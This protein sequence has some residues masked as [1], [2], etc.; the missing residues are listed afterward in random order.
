[1]DARTGMPRWEQPISRAFHRPFVGAPAPR[2]LGVTDHGTVFLYDYVIDPTVRN[3]SP[4]GNMCVLAFSGR[5]G[6]PLGFYPIRDGFRKDRENYDDIVRVFALHGQP[7]QMAD[8]DA[9]FAGF[10]AEWLG[11]PPP[12]Q[13]A[14]TEIYTSPRGGWN[15]NL[16]TKNTGVFG[17]PFARAG[18][19]PPLIGGEEVTATGSADLFFRWNPGRYAQHLRLIHP[20]PEHWEPNFVPETQFARYPVAQCPG[21]VLLGSDYANGFVA[22]LSPDAPDNRYLRW[23]R[24]W[25]FSL[26][27]PAVYGDEILLGAGLGDATRAIVSL[28]AGS[29]V[30]RWT[31]APEGL[32]PD[33]LRGDM[34]SVTWNID[35]YV[36]GTSLDVPRSTPSGGTGAS[37][38]GPGPALPGRSRPSPPAGQDSAL[39]LDTSH[40]IVSRGTQAAPILT[41]VGAHATNPGLVATGKRVYGVVCGRVVALDT[42]TGKLLWEWQPHA[43]GRAVPPITTLVAAS[44]H[45]FLCQS[46]IPAPFQLARLIAL[47]L[48][49]GKEEW[50]S[51]IPGTGSLVLT[52]GL[53]IL[54]VG[55]N[56]HTYAPAER[57]FRLAIDSS[58]SV[59][60]EPPRD[61]EELPKGAPDAAPEP[62]PEGADKPEAAKKP[63][64]ER[65]ADATVLRLRWGAPL[66][67]MVTQVKARRL[68]APGAPMLLVMDWMDATRSAAV[69]LGGGRTFAPDRVAAFARACG[70]LAAIA[71][72]AH[73]DLAPEVNVYLAHHPERFE[74]VGALLREAAQRV[75]EA[76]GGTQTALS[77]NVECL[78]R[79]YGR[80]EYQLFGPVE[81][82]QMPAFAGLLP[83]I[84][85]VEEVGLASRP[86]A[87]FGRA[88]DLPGDYFLSLR[89]ALGKKPVLVTQLSVKVDEQVPSGEA[90]QAGFVKRLLQAC[91]W[92]DAP[93]VAYP[94]AVPPEKGNPFALKDGDQPRPALAVWRDTL[95]W[96]RVRRLSSELARAGKPEQSAEEPR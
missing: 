35:Y 58:R 67:E 36:P 83:L 28:D 90:E 68:A 16:G 54:S 47:R 69:G 46:M 86:Q 89:E 95:A 19:G 81:R 40:R 66:E 61:E 51:E 84:Q 8:L 18:M 53:V 76:S 75:K 26:G 62:K 49:D 57:T 3:A 41:T 44:T 33:R 65:L 50:S 94:E 88:A 14:P 15:W 48:E 34:A 64:E 42:E 74:A 29:G 92:L 63:S 31:Y 78:T 38:R 56:I 22:V 93:L 37:G 91:Y 4:G 11:L 71:H 7:D 80:K 24:D 59:D 60:Y 25:P 96:K 27:L 77:L 6:V 20:R 79:R 52:R 45:L 39:R 72:P 23:H 2:W 13:M 30:T 17:S 55:E 85:E 21:G 43:A 9:P 1:M 73:F 87:A 12:Q 5:E 32:L 70:Q 82:S 10:Y